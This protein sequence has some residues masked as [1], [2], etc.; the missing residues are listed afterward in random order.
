MRSNLFI[1]LSFLVIAAGCKSKA[2]F[3]YSQK[4]VEIENSI[5]PDIQ[6]TENRVGKFF[7]NEQ[8]DSAKAASQHMEDKIDSKIKE[9]EKMDA[10]KVAEADNFKKAYLKYFAYLKSIYTTYRLYAEETDI[11]KRESLRQK[12]IN[13]ETEK[14]GAI[15]EVQ[16]VQAKFAK[17]NGFRLE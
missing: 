1:I 8:Y 14:H 2:A 3:N 5:I 10:P 13:I 17:A 6:D 9:V 12:I 15:A 16:K 4:L 11:A 7:S